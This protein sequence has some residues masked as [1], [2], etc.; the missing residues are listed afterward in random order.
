MTT[1]DQAR[2][3]LSHIKRR[4]CG[5]RH[6]NWDS[7]MA[8]WRSRTVLA[9][10]C[11]AALSAIEA[12]GGADD[13]H[14]FKNFHRLLCERFD[15]THDEKDWRRDQV[16]LIEWIAR[17]AALSASVPDGVEPV[18]WQHRS[19]FF[20]KD[21]HVLCPWSE[22]ENG[23]ASAQIKARCSAGFGDFDERELVPAAALTAMA[24][25]L[26]DARAEIE[27][28]RDCLRERPNTLLIAHENGDGER[29]TRIAAKAH[30]RAEAA[31]ATVS[32]LT[33]INAT[34]MGDDEAAPRYTT[35]R[36]RQEVERQTGDLRAEVSM[37]RERLEKAG[38]DGWNACRKSIYAVCEDVQNEA[39]RLQMSAKPGTASEEQHATGYYVG[40]RYAAKSIARGFNSM[41]ARDD[42]N[43]TEAARRWTEEK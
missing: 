36:L 32:R 27:R 15:Y 21:S 25:D 35:K 8:V 34:L 37:L 31:E 2:E 18:A 42:D 19:R 3:A 5:E 12:D 29:L 14:A 38:E 11:D 33:A 4:V 20:N 26:G 24:R 1:L 40:Q 17:R 10:I 30:A 43:F 41:N 39:D 23:R 9:D 28:L 22:W 16:S 6:P 7:D 13:S